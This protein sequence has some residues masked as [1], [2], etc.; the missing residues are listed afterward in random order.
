MRRQDFLIGSAAIAIAGALGGCSLFADPK[1]LRILGLTGAIPSKVL[2]EFETKY[3]KPT[4]LK[5]EATPEAIWKLLK[6]TSE[7]DKIPDVASLGDAWLDSAIAQNLISPINPTQITQWSKLSPIW[8][9]AATRNGQVW[10]IP[11]RWGMTA[12]AYRTD[13][14]SSPITSWADL[15]RSEL[16][17]KVTLPDDAREV[18]GLVLKKLGQF[19]KTPDLKVIAALKTELQQLQAQVLTYTSDT[20]LQPLLIGDSWAAVGWS[21][22]MIKAMEQNPDIAIVIPSEGTAMWTDMWV[23]PQKASR[24]DNQIFTQNWLNFCLEPAI[25]NQITALTASTATNADASLLPKSVTSDPIKFPNPHVL[26]KS[27][28][29]L[30]LSE[31]T[32][33]EYLQTW[34]NLRKLS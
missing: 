29:I 23:I 3:S 17:G 12:I 33:Q 7:P 6:E 15:W 16:T 5:T 18:I 13:K 1:R 34:E 21:Q 26:A 24:P 10:G 14:L 25:A 22:D 4:E 11:Y 30:P 8:Q 19:Y 31:I 32:K 2:K 27:E 9:Q 28:L 20:Y